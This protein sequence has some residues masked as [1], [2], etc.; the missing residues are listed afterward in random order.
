MSRALIGLLCALVFASCM[1]VLDGEEYNLA[2]Q[3]VRL[4]I[5]HTLGHPLAAHPV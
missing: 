2:G 1:P 4:T 5:L 3:E